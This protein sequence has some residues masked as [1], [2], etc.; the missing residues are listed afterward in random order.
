MRHPVRPH[1]Q[2]GF[3]L[4]EVL[5]AFVIFA[6]GLLGAAGLQLSSIRSNQYSAN[7]AIGAS[8]AR[9]YGELMQMYPDVV[10]ST[11]A[12]TTST[13]FID[14]NTITAYTNAKDC[15][16]TSATCTTAAMSAS[17]QQDWTSRLKMM[18][19][20]GRAVVCRDSTPFDP[21]L[22]AFTWTCDNTGVMVVIKMGWQVKSDKG[23]TT[24]T[25]TNT[26]DS[27]RL[28]MTLFGNLSDYTR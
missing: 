10:L 1:A 23:E 20:N 25:G 4:I 3:S 21:S 17:A 19:P 27:P 13:F 9:D 14:T 11:T 22:S 12:G 2:S 16:G 8:L 6:I 15:T 18:L 5:V 24:F 26:T 7:A 28:V